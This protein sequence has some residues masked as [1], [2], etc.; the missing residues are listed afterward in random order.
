MDP[1]LSLTSALP[2][3][4]GEGGAAGVSAGRLEVLARLRERIVAFAASRGAGAH[5]EDLAQEVLVLLHTKYGHL[6]RAE[7]LVPL[8]FQIL[9]FKLAAHR[10]RAARRGEYDAVDLDAFPPP[11]DAPDPAMVLERKELLARLMGGIAQ[12]GERCRELFRLKLQGRTFA[13]IQGLLG[14]ASLNTVYTWDHRCRKQLLDTL[15]GRWEGVGSGPGG[16]GAP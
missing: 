9:R 14:A 4:E 16:R 8:A 1:D 2:I 6:E 7:D 5:A 3:P 10:R 15:G 11:S 12:M 13:E